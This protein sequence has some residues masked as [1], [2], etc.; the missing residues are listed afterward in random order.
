MDDDLDWFEYVDLEQCV[1]S[2]NGH[3]RSGK[4]W[5]AVRD[6]GWVLNDGT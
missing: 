6:L 5:E 1:L 2:W 3:S 4:F